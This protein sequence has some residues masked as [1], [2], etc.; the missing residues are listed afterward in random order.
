VFAYEL[1]RGFVVS[2]VTTLPQS[3][4]DVIYAA[5]AAIHDPDPA[6][7]DAARAKILEQ[8]GPDVPLPEHAVLPFTIAQSGVLMIASTTAMWTGFALLST[9]IWPGGLT[10]RHFGMSIRRRRG[11]RGSRLFGF[12]RVALFAI[13][14]TLAYGATFAVISFGSAALG[15]TLFAVVVA[16]HIAGVVASI[17]DPTRGPIDRLLRSRIVPR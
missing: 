7:V 13:P 3:E 12:L 4:Q 15:W 8:R 2:I 17:V 11:R 5:Q 14:L 9:L 1:V 6:S 10:F 16:L